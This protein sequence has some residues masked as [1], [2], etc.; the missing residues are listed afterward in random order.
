[1]LREAA[2][3]G[4]KR[5]ETHR[6]GPR[7]SQLEDANSPRNL[8]PTVGSVKRGG[9][10]PPPRCDLTGTR[11]LLAFAGNAPRT[12]APDIPDYSL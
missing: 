12:R 8:E 10:L 6:I 9:T 1:V 2:A 11:A 4:E 5:L 3:S 7:G